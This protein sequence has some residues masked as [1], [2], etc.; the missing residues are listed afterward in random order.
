PPPPLPFPI[1]LAPAA[2]PSLAARRSTGPPP[3]PRL[4]PS[5]RTA[6]RIPAPDC[7]SRRPAL[8]PT[9]AFLRRWPST[10]S[11]T[12]RAPLS[13]CLSAPHRLL[14]TFHTSGVGSGTRTPHTSSPSPLGYSFPDARPR[15]H[16][17]PCSPDR[18]NNSPRW[19]SP[20]PA[21]LPPPSSAP[22]PDDSPE[23]PCPARAA[24]GHPR[25]PRAAL[26]LSSRQNFSLPGPWHPQATRPLQRPA[27]SHPA[28]SSS[29][30]TSRSLPA[31]FV[32]PS[33]GIPRLVARRDDFART[34]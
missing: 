31:R 14:A 17:K 27:P 7:A 12:R 1:L 32:P 16:P 24:A 3:G 4:H 15:P 23:T 26:R 34:G 10:P 28:S 6:G 13:S 9:P 20:A 19:F 33:M 25:S 22:R 8:C 5:P 29:G 21:A 2:A 30:E 11:Q 18:G